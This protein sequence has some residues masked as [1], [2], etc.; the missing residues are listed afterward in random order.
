MKKKLIL[1]KF[2]NEDEERDF[3]DKIDIIEYADAE[4]FQHFDVAAL[5]KKAQEKLKGRNVTMNLPEKWIAEAKQQA[6]KQDMPYQTYIKRI[7]HNGL[8]HQK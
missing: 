7:I 2:K 5:V 1:P 6:E 4:D 3:W 8:Y